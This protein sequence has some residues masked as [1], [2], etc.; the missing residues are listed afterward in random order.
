M[1][2]DLRLCALT[3]TL[4]LWLCLL[5]CVHG[6]WPHADYIPTLC[7]HCAYISHAPDEV[8]ICVLWYSAIWFVYLPNADNNHPFPPTRAPI[9]RTHI[10]TIIHIILPLLLCAI[11][12]HLLSEFCVVKQAE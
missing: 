4:L 1:A 7:V 8:A 11:F 5:A 6:G 10:R 9:Y 2:F 3:H 12:L